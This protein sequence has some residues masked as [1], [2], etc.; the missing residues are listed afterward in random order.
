[1]FGIDTEYYH[2][3]YKTAIENKNEIKRLI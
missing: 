3:S 1:M 2:K